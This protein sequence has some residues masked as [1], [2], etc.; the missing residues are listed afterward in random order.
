MI[1]KTEKYMNAS[2]ALF[3]VTRLVAFFI[4]FFAISKAIFTNSFSGREVMFFISYILFYFT[5]LLYQKKRK[6]FTVGYLFYFIV[7]FLAI[8]Y[9]SYKYAFRDLDMVYLSISNGILWPKDYFNLYILVFISITLFILFYLS[10]I[11]PINVGKINLSTYEPSSRVFNIILG[12][13]MIFPLYLIGVT[14]VAIL[15]VTFF[16]VNFLFK[17]N[18]LHFLYWVGFLISLFFIYGILTYRFRL[19]Q[20]VLPVLLFAILHYT[21][22]NKMRITKVKSLIYMGLGVVLISIYGIVSELIKLNL[23]YGESYSIQDFFNIMSNYELVLKWADRQFY[24]VVDVWYHLGG[25]IIDFVKEN[26]HFYYGITYIKPLSG[27]LGFEY[28]SLPKISAEMIRASYAQPGLL[29]EGYANFG[30]VGAIVNIL[31]VFF[32]MEFLFDLFLRRQTV[33]LLLL[34]VS[35]F[36]K[37]ILDGG[38]INS[39]IF[40]IIASLVTYFFNFIIKPKPKTL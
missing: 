29:A 3:F 18:K 5:S 34:S 8:V 38:T 25:N 14:E 9:S 13:F 20:F 36:P 28:V 31:L 19:I 27:I 32:V 2:E 39:A 21:V 24:R 23:Y 10:L 12:G 7:C 40:L 33:F 11:T 26:D 4:V 6:I 15:F 30:V 17:Q 22:R 1:A 16:T 35:V 37:I